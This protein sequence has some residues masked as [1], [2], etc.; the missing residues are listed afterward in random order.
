MTI[1]DD[2]PLGPL[3]FTIML[4]ND[5]RLDTEVAVRISLIYTEQLLKFDN[6]EGEF[7]E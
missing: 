7:D 3:G 2:L 4:I 6:I 1:D 5:F